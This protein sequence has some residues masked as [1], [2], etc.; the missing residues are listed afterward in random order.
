M[1]RKTPRHVGQRVSSKTPSEGLTKNL[2]G[3]GSV[4]QT[5][6]APKQM[7]IGLIGPLPGKDRFENFISSTSRDQER[8]VD[9][10]SSPS[11]RQEI[12]AC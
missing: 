4:L 9:A 7:L 3:S 8:W 10:C 1:A 12:G 2:L 11:L 5:P 6:A